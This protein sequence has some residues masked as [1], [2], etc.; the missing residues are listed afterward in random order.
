[1]FA[2]RAWGLGRPVQAFGLCQD[3]RHSL[4]A[5]SDH[6]AG[7]YRQVVLLFYIKKMQLYLKAIGEIIA[8]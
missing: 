8:R 6:E 3:R 1:M 2:G 4:S 7:I 5:P